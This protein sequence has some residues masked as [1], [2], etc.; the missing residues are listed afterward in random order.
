MRTSHWILSQPRAQTG[1][2]VDYRNSRF[3]P[4]DSG[5]LSATNVSDLELKWAFAYPNAIQ[6]RSQP[7]VAG[8]TLFVGSQNGT[9]YALDAKTGCVRWTYRASA[10]VRTGISISSWT[11]GEENTS[12]VS[13]FR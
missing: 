9:V 2:G 12:P 6:A 3:Q 13:L 1:W 8:A 7:I 5:G 10:E 11:E 4:A